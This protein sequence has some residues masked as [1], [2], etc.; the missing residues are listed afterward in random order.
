MSKSDYNF[1]FNHIYFGI[2]S[3]DINEKFRDTGLA[4]NTTSFDRKSSFTCGG[5]L[6]SR[7]LEEYKL[8]VDKILQA[9]SK[10]D[11]SAA[12]S[13]AG[14]FVFQLEY[15]SGFKFWEYFGQGIVT[16]L[17]LF[18]KQ[19]SSLIA[20]LDSLEVNS[21][22]KEL[23]REQLYDNLTQYELEL[24]NYYYA[25]EECLKDASIESWKRLPQKFKVK[26]LPFDNLVAEN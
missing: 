10:E 21:E 24:L 18:Y 9:K 16:H 15:L 12:L 13:T 4:F 1:L 25:S 6:K 19:C 2:N 23:Y 17:S 11:I 3:E 7:I 8:L 5:W 20:Y 22:E 14:D 26:V